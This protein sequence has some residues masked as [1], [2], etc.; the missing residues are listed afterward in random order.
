M[1]LYFD[2]REGVPAIDGALQEIV[3]ALREAS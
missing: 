2:G 1:V 3:P